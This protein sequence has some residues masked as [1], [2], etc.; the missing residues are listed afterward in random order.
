MKSPD[1]I[2]RYEK[3]LSF[4]I[5]PTALKL[6]IIY[7]TPVRLLYQDLFVALEG[8]IT[9]KQKLLMEEFP[10]QSELFPSRA[11]KLEMEEQYFYADILKNRF[12]S[13]M[14]ILLINA[15]IIN[16]SNTLSDVKQGLRPF[17]EEDQI[18]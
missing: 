9:E 10:V 18:Q 17:D 16:M 14:E 4:P 5:L 3:S 7:K 13:P 12:P 2:Y 15:H 11:E 6:E 1:E 8:E